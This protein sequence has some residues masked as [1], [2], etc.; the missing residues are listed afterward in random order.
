MFNWSGDWEHRQVR[1]AF[2]LS[3]ARN[4]DPRD[5][6]RADQSNQHDPHMSSFI[7]GH[8]GVV[9]G[10]A[11]VQLELQEHRE[12]RAD[13]HSKDRNPPHDRFILVDV[14]QV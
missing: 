14:F 11:P 7:G 12:I 5:H 9:H 13:Y 2:A 4:G 1:I 3:A 8:N 6:N 10:V